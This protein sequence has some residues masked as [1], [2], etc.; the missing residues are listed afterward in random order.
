MLVAL[1]TDNGEGHL[2]QGEVLLKVSHLVVEYPSAGGG[3][4]HAVSD[5]SID[6]EEGETLGLVGESGCGKSTLG[7]AILQL[8][9]P[10]SGSVIFEDLDLTHVRGKQLRRIRQKVQIIF[11]DPISS[12]NPRHRIFDIVADPLRMWRTG[13]KAEIAAKVRQVLQDVGLDPDAVGRRRP[14]ELSGGQCQRVCIAR[15][16]IQEPKVLVCDEPV[17]SLDVS[18]QAQV[19]NLLEDMKLRYGLTLLFIAHDLAV[20]KSI[21][22]RVAV[23]YLGKLCEVSS[24]DD[25][26]RRPAHPYTRALL[27]AIPIPD[28]AHKQSIEGVITGELP[29]PVSPPSGCRFRTRC[30]RADEICAVE[31]PPMRELAEGH[32]VACHHPLWDGTSAAEPTTS[33]AVAQGE[34]GS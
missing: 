14:F 13:T 10:K 22:D 7:R 9:R 31:E 11:Q 1:M 25:L 28:P 6:L 26:Y 24:A 33:V 17:S 16:L 8:P 12:L 20:V 19:L 30:P 2:R 21:S 3:R 27:R 18:V 23:M 15:A 32:H 4:V 5:V 34:G 29:S